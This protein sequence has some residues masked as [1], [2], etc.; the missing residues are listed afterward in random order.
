V[1]RGQRLSQSVA[2]QPGRRSARGR[3][4]PIR[5]RYRQA[6]HARIAAFS[7]GLSL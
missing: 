4:R 2:R 3:E 1:S 6:E 5:P 7:G